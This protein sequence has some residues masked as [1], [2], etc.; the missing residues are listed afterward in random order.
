MVDG[1]FVEEDA[2]S[3]KKI[4]LSWHVT[5]DIV[6]ALFYLLKLLLQVRI[7]VP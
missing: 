2:K 3:I 5:E 4:P 6:L 1:L 7:Q